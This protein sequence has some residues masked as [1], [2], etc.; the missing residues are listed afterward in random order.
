MPASSSSLRRP[1]LSTSR[2]LGRKHRV[3]ERVAGLAEEN[4]ESCHGV[5][6]RAMCGVVAVQ[7]TNRPP[8]VHDRQR[9]DLC[10]QRAAELIDELLV[11]R[12]AAHLAALHLAG[13]IY[14]AEDR[15]L[16]ARDV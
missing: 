8:G 7:N 2:L 4:L 1:G 6:R 10:R 12:R 9:H 16:R 13:R 14:I 3:A 15:W 5:D 11:G